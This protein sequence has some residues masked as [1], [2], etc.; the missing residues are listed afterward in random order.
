MNTEI[1]KDAIEHY[2]ADFVKKTWPD[3][4]YKWQAIK[5]FQDNWDID[6]EDFAGMLKKALKE[7]GNIL[8]SRNNFSGDM[9]KSFAEKTPDEVRNMFVELF[10]ESKDV[11]GRILKFKEKAQELLEKY[12]DESKPNHY[13][14]EHAITTYLWLR[15]P[16]KYYIYKFTVAKNVS[17]KLDAGYVFNK[18]TFRQKLE[19]FYALY[20]ELHT[21]VI[22]DEDLIALLKSQLTETEYPDP[23]YRTLTTDVS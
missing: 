23:E 18:N 4:R 3:E 5:C 14:N 1:L 22:K 11:I 13:Q 19:K 10:D 16:D 12:G 9:I 8:D 2:K 20:E 7:I 21:E 17:Q 6:A 15:Y